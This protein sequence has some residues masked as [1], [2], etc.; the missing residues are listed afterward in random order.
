MTGSVRESESKAEN[1]NYSVTFKNKTA[2]DFGSQTRFRSTGYYRFSPIKGK[3]Q[4][5]LG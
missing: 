2:H 5:F 4:V 3:Y 1:S